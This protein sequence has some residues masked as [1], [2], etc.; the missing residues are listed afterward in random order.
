MI[1]RMLSKE[2]YRVVHASNGPD[3][4]ELA[5]REKPDVITLDI[6]MPGMDGWSV[7]SKLKADASLSAIPVVV[8]TII[9]DRSMGFALGA[10]DYLSKPVDREQLSEVLHRVRAE[11]AE[12]SVL[13]IEDDAVQ[14]SLI[15][16]LLEK[17]GWSVR[18][19]ENGRVGLERIAEHLPG[20]VLL[21][22]MM[23]EMDGFEFIEHLRRREDAQDLP[24]VV[25]TAKDLTEQD[26]KRLRGSVENV[27]Q[28]GGKMSEIV[29]EVRRRLDHRKAHAN[30]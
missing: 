1:T 28:K 14:R 9:D 20:L 29:K 2:G 26:R 10:A 27:L 11:A 7:L 12:R 23:P 18:E 6:M 8:V 4:L 30:A 21:D 17:D 25:L 16:S 13:V 15:R 24:V 19:A 22:L 5:A 3:G